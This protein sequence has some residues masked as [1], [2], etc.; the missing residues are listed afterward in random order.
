MAG[1]NI[2]PC[3]IK[4]TS[5]LFF[6]HRNRMNSVTKSDNISVL[7]YIMAC[8]GGHGETTHTSMDSEAADGKFKYRTILFNIIINIITNICF[9]LLIFIIIIII[10]IIM[11]AYLYCVA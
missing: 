8:L 2:K 11:L 6:L 5:T 1:S 10:I 9:N 4:P 3:I 7:V